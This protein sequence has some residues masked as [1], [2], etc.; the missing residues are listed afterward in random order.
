MPPDTQDQQ[1]PQYRSDRAVVNRLLAEAV[2]DYGLAELGRLLIRY[3][4]FPGARDIQT[5]L[6]KVL[7]HWGLT[8]ETLYERTRAI[9]AQGQVYRDV[10]RNREDWS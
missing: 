4:N 8:E 6:G 10:G 9:H 2:S 3:K 7:K 5:D 1:H